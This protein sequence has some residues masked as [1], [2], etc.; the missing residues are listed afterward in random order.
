MQ[1]A[2]LYRYPVKGL[3][4][5]RLPSVQ[6]EAGACFPHDRQYALLRTQSAFDAA[7]PVW[8]AKANFIMLMLHETIAGLK[9]RYTDEDKSLRIATP[10]RRE[11]TFRLDTDDGR[12]ALE[13]FFQE[14]MP[15]RLPGKPRLVAAQG[16]HFTDKAVKFIS[17]INLASVRELEKQWGESL[18]PLRFRANV[19]IDGAEPFSELRWLGHEIGLGPVRARVVLRNGRCAATNVNPASG[20]R[21]RDV[22][23]K[24]RQ[25]FGHKDLGVYLGIVQGGSIREGDRVTVPFIADA[26]APAAAATGKAAGQL[27]CTACYYLFDPHASNAVHATAGDLPA[28]WRCPDCGATRETVVAADGGGRPA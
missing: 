23:G 11:L 15:D 21:D 12:E 27:I 17:L 14:F 4:P 6:I 1:I 16:H 18:D 2:G 10:D 19:Y 22:P 26:S 7:A 24:L 20:V 9:T 8:L 25:Q 3:S 28:D 13:R 5:E